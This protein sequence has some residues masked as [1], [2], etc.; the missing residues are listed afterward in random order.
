[1]VAR[2]PALAPAPARPELDALIAKARQATLSE[3][4][5]A[6]QRASFAYGNAP[7]GS[8]ITKESARQSAK[9]VRLRAAE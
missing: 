2:K 8:S 4:M 1:M 7:S 5:L 3:E 6:E 9:T